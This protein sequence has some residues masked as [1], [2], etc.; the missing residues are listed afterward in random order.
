MF[1][2]KTFA[3]VFCKCFAT[4]LQIC[5]SVKRLQNI[6]DVVTCKINKTL[7]HF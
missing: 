4:V 6:L 5:F 7:K 1:Y 2:A 3:K